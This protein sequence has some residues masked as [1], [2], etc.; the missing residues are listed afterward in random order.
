M[1]KKAVRA[2]V[3]NETRTRIIACLGTGHKTVNEL[4][5][6]CRLSQSAVSQHLMRLRAA[7]AVASEKRGR[8]RVY[9][10][11]HPSIVRVCRSIINLIRS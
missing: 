6:V 7:G 3:S 8:E 9:R 4:R 11:T 2:A 1:H 10:A 5:A